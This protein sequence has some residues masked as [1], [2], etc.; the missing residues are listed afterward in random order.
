MAKRTPNML[1]SRLASGAPVTFTQLQAALGN[2]SRATTF[3]YLKQ[4][5]H[6]RSYN[7]S[8]RYYT[9]RDPLRFD[10]YGLL[11]LGDVH[12]SRE[13]TLAATVRR[14]RPRV[15][16]RL[17]AEGTAEPAAR[18]KCRRSCWPRCVRGNFAGS[19]WE[20]SG[21]IV[22]PTPLSV[23]PNGARARHA[24]TNSAPARPPPRWKRRSSSRCWLEL[25]RHP[26]S[27]P[28]QVAR[29]LQG[30][31]PPIALPQVSAVFTRFDLAQVAQKGG[32]ADC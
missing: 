28:T 30:H 16:C 15:R 19:A 3:R 12:F 11:S 1:A 22:P 24:S 10:R 9:H 13:G 4:V 21:S 23:T 2:A 31:A 6:L 32:S 8:S 18:E 27:S 20:E 14:P 25:I 7:H 29:R 26:G 17:H 5:R